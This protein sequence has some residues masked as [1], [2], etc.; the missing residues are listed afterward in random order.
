MHNNSPKNTR[1]AVELGLYL[2]I[3][4]ETEEASKEA[5]ELARGLSY[6]IT[7]GECEIAKINVRRYIERERAGG[8]EYPQSP[9]RMAVPIKRAMKPK[10]LTREIIL[11]AIGCPNLVMMRVKNETPMPFTP[12]YLKVNWCFVYLK[13]PGTNLMLHYLTTGRMRDQVVASLEVDFPRLKDLTL[14][15]WVE[16]GQKLVEEVK[17]RL[18]LSNIIETVSPSK[19]PFMTEGREVNLN[20]WDT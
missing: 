20:E 7:Y 19:T 4:A 11:D 5:L 16:N 9:P 8:A 17:T 12:A 13:Q 18:G 2:A 1:E 10:R 3:T 6:Q 15:Q 14:E